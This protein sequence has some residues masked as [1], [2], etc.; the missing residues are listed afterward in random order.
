MFKPF[1]GNCA[2]PE[3]GKTGVLIPVKSGLCNKC[4]HERKQKFK[5]FG[6]NRIATGFHKKSGARKESKTSKRKRPNDNNLE[7]HSG[8]FGVAL[9]HER[10]SRKMGKK[11]KSPICKARKPIQYSKKG[12]GEAALFK[13]IF[14]TRLQETYPVCPSCDVC[15]SPL[16][17]EPKTF[18]FSHVL[19][20]S[21]YPSLRLSNNNIW[22]C[23]L[24]CH[25]EW[26]HGDRSH[27]KFEKKRQAAEKLKIEYY[28][29]H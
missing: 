14:E 20:K 2:N 16:G 8:T 19:A 21:T 10:P 7:K 4:N 23:C 29:N 18:F 5:S 15:G 27:P 12:T 24:K 1:I 28:K 25:Q 9:K 6:I 17:F 13:K 11:S 22:L 26:D 3:C